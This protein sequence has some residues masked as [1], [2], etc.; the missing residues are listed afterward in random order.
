[1]YESRLLVFRLVIVAATVGLS[2]LAWWG[3]T[4]PRPRLVRAIVIW[5]AAM[6]RWI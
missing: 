6:M 5:V 4:S 2:L 1:M 3:A